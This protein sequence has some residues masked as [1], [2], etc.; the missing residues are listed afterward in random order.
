MLGAGYKVVRGKVGAREEVQ[1]GL[2]AL[3]VELA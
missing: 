1:K 3:I 2:A